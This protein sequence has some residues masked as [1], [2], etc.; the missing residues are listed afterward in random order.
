[1]GTDY[2]AVLD[3][4]NFVFCSDEFETVHF[5]THGLPSQVSDLVVDETSTADNVVLVWTKPYDGG[6][7]IKMYYVNIM[8][9]ETVK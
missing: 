9:G 5:A 1:M 3:Y 8:Q 7:P 4:C 6:V 2:Y